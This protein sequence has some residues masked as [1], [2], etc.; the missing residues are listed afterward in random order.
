[1]THSDNSDLPFLDLERFESEEN[2]LRASSAYEGAL[3]RNDSDYMQMWGIFMA[4]SRRAAA[5]GADPSAFVNPVTG[6]YNLKAVEV[7]QRLWDTARKTIS[8]LNKMR[9][10]DRMTGHILDE[11][12][13][14]FSEAVAAP[15][16]AELRS[17]VDL[18]DES[19]PDGASRALQQLLTRGI[20][21]IFST[22]AATTLPALKAEYGLLQ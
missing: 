2:E 14:S 6:Q 21:D 20:V 22:A 10:Q 5:M 11:H 8:D 4:L 15:L 1:M 17:I 19:D 13:R 3:G 18:L 16:G 7:W 9:N 12:T